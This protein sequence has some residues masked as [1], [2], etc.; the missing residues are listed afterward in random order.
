[1]DMS[2]TPTVFNPPQK[3]RIYRFRG[4]M[5]V[6]LRDVTEFIVVPSGAHRLKTA[7]GHSHVVQPEWLYL[8]INEN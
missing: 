4:D 3:S 8:D 1:M 2:M 5:M 6:I 7:D